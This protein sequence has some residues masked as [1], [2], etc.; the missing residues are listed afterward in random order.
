MPATRKHPLVRSTLRTDAP[1]W[2]GATCAGHSAPALGQSTQLQISSSSGHESSYPKPIRPSSRSGAT[3]CRSAAS[4]GLSQASPPPLAHQPF[5]WEST[6]GR[7]TQSG[8]KNRGLAA[9]QRQ[10]TRARRPR[11]DSDG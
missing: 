1:I 7:P 6:Q 5:R 8:I 11:R 10:G 4:S 9:R 3:W 2:H